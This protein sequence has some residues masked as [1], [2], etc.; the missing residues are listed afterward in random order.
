M[1]DG[2]AR[3]GGESQGL[4]ASGFGGRERAEAGVG[5]GVGRVQGASDLVHVHGGGV[6]AGHVGGGV[7][8]GLVVVEHDGRD[9]LSVRGVPVEAW[10]DISGV[11]IGENGD[12]G[13]CDGGCRGVGGD[14]GDD[15]VVLAYGRVG[16]QLGGHDAA[17]GVPGELDGLAR[18]DSG[19]FHRLL[20][21]VE[22]VG[23]HAADALEVGE[24]VLR[25]I[26]AHCEGLRAADING[27]RARLRPVLPRRD[28][29][30]DSD[31][32]VVGVAAV[33]VDDVL[34][35]VGAPS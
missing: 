20:D 35:E 5:R 29:F 17:L 6:L 13:R 33:H 34:D 15:V 2:R 3:A 24:H 10:D 31:L 16:G 22:L 19:V 27:P 11:L 25:S 8:R 21:G 1:V 9:V 12:V 30:L 23:V 4:G 14:D 18:R 32:A 26:R 28:V 7:A